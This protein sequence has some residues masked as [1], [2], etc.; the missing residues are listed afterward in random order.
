MVEK[1]DRQLKKLGAGSYSTV[2]LLRLQFHLNLN[3]SSNSSSGKI[4]LLWLQHPALNQDS[5]ILE[6]ENFISR[7]P[8]YG[9]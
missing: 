8:Q 3:V 4:E 5:E 6:E 7:K 1:C 9:E 2:I